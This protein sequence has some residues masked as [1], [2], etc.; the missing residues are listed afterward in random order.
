[1][2]KSHEDFCD[3][4]WETLRELY[5]E[6]KL[7]WPFGEEDPPEDLKEAL[8]R[9]IDLVFVA[10]TQDATMGIRA[11]GA[12]PVQDILAKREFER[13][14]VPPSRPQELEWSR[15]ERH[16]DVRARSLATLIE[17]LT[18]A[19]GGSIESMYLVIERILEKMRRRLHRR[20][21][22]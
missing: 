8:R 6:K 10:V 20:R 14:V 2:Q 7:Q 4:Y 19:E 16:M 18:T 5:D 3:A 15:S 17:E 22:Q 21:P 9:C 11:A 1:M 13:N 12:P